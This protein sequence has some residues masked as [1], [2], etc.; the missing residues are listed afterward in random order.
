MKVD[1]QGHELPVLQ[2]GLRSLARVDIAIIESSFANDYADL[3]PSFGEVTGL[4][5]KHGLFPIIFLDYGRTLGPYAWQRDCIFV[6]SQY[7]PN[8]FD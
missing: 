8:I 2:G 1:V 7:L 4:L 6:K 3:E 5:T